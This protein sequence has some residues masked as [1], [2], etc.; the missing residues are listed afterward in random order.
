LS[1]YRWVGDYGG[2]V[3]MTTFGAS[4]PGKDVFERF[5]F[6]AERV[7]QAGR[8]AVERANS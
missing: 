7:A 6:T 1:W 2:I 8:S 3:G 5:G 4:G